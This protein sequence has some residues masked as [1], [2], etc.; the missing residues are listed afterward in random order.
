[1]G[2]V[3]SVLRE[4]GVT[5]EL[6]RAETAKVEDLARGDVLLLASGTWNTGGVEGQLHPYMYEFLLKRAKDASIKGKQAAIIALGDDR[7]RY[8]AR[9]GEHLRSFV[10]THGGV[11]I[12]DP[13]AVINEPY[14][15]ED[16]VQRW[17]QKL[18]Q[19]LS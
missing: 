15:Q 9:A 6:Q 17:T 4:K 3:S 19:E 1:M 2:I 14:G 18:I 10:T 16:R 5:V 13:L 12:T 11:L 8:T 7:Y